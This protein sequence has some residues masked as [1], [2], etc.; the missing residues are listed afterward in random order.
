MY[1]V[2]QATCQD[3]ILIP[4]EQLSAELEGKTLQITL[5]ELPD[6]AISSSQSPDAIKLHQFLT[7]VQQF[8]AQLSPEYQFN[9]DELYERSDFS[10]Y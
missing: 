6:P 1:K 8:S 5:Q 3:G 7:H 2:L 10:R 9:R 4:S